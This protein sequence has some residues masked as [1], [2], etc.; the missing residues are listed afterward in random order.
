MKEKEIM[1]EK[2][3]YLNRCCI[4]FLKNGDDINA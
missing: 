2:E 4:L 1:N 3:K